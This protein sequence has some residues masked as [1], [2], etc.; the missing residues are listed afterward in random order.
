[1]QTEKGSSLSYFTRRTTFQSLEPDYP[2]QRPG[3]ATLR[4][5]YRI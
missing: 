2:E 5:K 4:E 3:M 1:M